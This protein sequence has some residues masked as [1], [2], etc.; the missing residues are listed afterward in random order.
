MTSAFAP[1]GAVNQSTT[2]GPPTHRRPRNLRSRRFQ[3]T[4][5][6]SP[7]S[8]T[9]RMG[10]FRSSPQPAGSHA[11]STTSECRSTCQGRSPPRRPRRS[12]PRWCA[13]CLRCPR[14]ARSGWRLR[15]SR[16]LLPSSHRD[17]ALFERRNRHI[18]SSRPV[19]LTFQGPGFMPRSC[20]A[21][22]MLARVDRQRDAPSTTRYR[23]P[24]A[25]DFNPRH[26]AGTVTTR[27]ESS[28]S[29]AAC[30]ARAS[31]AAGASPDRSAKVNASLKRVHAL[32][33][34]QS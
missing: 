6:Y 18:R 29:M 21:H 19:T 25:H 7:S 2:P 17:G 4:L 8:D 3:P 26:G 22:R 28:G 20:G 12:W 1:F 13:E 11:C 30:R 10:T 16:G 31:A 32:Q 27:Y 33:F 23:R 24:V 14:R 15:W 34:V 5:R 9:P